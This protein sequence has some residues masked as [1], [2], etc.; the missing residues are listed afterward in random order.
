MVRILLG[1]ASPD[2]D[3]LHDCRKLVDSKWLVLKPHLIGLFELFPWL[4]KES[5]L[6]WVELVE[7]LAKARK[8]IAVLTCAI[9]AGLSLVA[10]FVG[11]ASLM[12]L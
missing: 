5:L 10:R 3:L 4:L 7:V 6:P 12:I 2:G 1:Q 8:R 9:Q 11:E